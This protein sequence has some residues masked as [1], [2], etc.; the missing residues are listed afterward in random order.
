MNTLETEDN[1]F[2]HLLE[3]M[4][5]LIPIECFLSQTFS[6]NMFVKT[7]DV[8]FIDQKFKF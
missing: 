1:I 3:N 7:N 4:N 6:F 8:D 2:F 5:I